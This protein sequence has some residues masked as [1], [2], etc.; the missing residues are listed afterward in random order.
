MLEDGP[1]K[2]WNVKEFAYALKL[3]ILSFQYTSSE[4]GP[5]SSASF[6]ICSDCASTCSICL[7]QPVTI[8]SSCV[9]RSKLPAVREGG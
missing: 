8:P 1:I 2:V 4:L 7:H 5:V 9:T 6:L 3:A